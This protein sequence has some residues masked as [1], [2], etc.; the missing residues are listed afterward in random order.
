MKLTSKNV[1]EFW[2]TKSNKKVKIS[3]FDESD[4]YQIDGQYIDD[5]G[6]GECWTEKGQMWINRTDINDLEKQITP[7]KDPEYFI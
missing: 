2:I 1:G 3:Y 4:D 5:Q 7:E 6:V